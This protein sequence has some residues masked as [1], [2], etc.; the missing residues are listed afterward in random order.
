MKQGIKNI[1]KSRDQKE[2]KNSPLLMWLFFVSEKVMSVVN[3]YKNKQK[4]IK[5]NGMKNAVEIV[6]RS[7]FFKNI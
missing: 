3:S 1:N 2:K 4:L 6:A 5:Q 7:I